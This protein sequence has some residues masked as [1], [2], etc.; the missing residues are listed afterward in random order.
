MKHAAGAVALLIL[1]VAVAG[2]AVPLHR[3]NNEK[4]QGKVVLKIEPAD[5]KVYLDNV[6]IGKARSF[7]DSAHPLVVDMGVHVL[8]FN[9]KGYMSEL[10][11]V[12]TVLGGQEI[13]LEMR[14]HP[15]APE[16][17]KKKKKRP[18]ERKWYF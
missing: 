9:R 3:L 15:V 13:T 17:K 16:G 10:R 14:L 5:T 2:C 6:Y 12:E 18:E 4:S 1:I 7:D 11:E 8:E